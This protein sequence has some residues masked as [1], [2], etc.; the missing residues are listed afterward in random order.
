MVKDAHQA[1]RLCTR[2]SLCV[3]LFSFFINVLMLTVPLYSLQIFDRVLGGRSEETL[4][5]LTIVAVGAL[6]VHAAL[7]VV[8]S[9]I[10]VHIGNWLDRTLGPSILSQAIEGSA[11]GRGRTGIQGLRDLQSL[12]GFLTGPTIFTVFDAP[13][14]P[15]YMGVVYLVHPL[16]GMT[17]LVGAVPLF[18][19]GL[20][21][22]W[23]TRAP[24]QMAN[25]VATR[26]LQSAESGARNAEVIDAMGMLPQIV[27]RW[28]QEGEQVI[29]LQATASHRAGLIGGATKF[30]RSA[31][32]IALMAVGAWL[33]L[34][35]EV[36]PGAM[37]A[38]SII[39]GRALA[40]VEQL[41]GSWRALAGARQSYA[42]L[43]ELLRAKP[44]MRGTTRYPAPA[45]MLSVENL[46]FVPPGSSKP[47]LNGVSF[48]LLPGESLGVVGPSGAGKSVLAR[49]LTGVW[50]ATAGKV[51]LDGVDVFS[52]DRADFGRHV[53]YL[54]Q[55]VELFA[56]TIKE[57]I[58]RLDDAEDAA[59]DAD[60]IA[61]AQ[62]ANAHDLILRLP[63][64][65]D[66]DIGEAGALLSGGQRQRV[67]LARAL[68]G[69]PRFIVLDEPNSNLD[70][71]GEA[72]LTEAL[73]AAKE[74]GATI[75]VIAHRMNVLTSV[76]KIL[77]VKQ[78][79][80]ELFGPRAEVL[81]RLQPRPVPVATQMQPRL[82]AV[83]ANPTVV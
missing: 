28:R 48:R 8:R 68:Y 66:T 44:L 5:M 71:E 21:N 70:S 38:G 75:I 59:E 61:A 64:G 57:N 77:L 33:A 13:W 65:Y 17:A 76:D 22:D 46:S 58:A 36:T 20:L 83:P 47:V 40:P 74:R 80:I 29:A 37:I 4:V 25:K 30:L 54:P 14:V 27:N 19:V 2:P 73:T 26:Q 82:A 63:K 16:M 81:A 78:G 24:I 56:G 79:R 32:Q 69:N 15:V 45:G 6:A 67:A 49:L 42:Q 1:L 62:A 43:N 39:M 35:Q 51:R 12:R 11:T 7:E 41:I 18:M 53:G 34:N 60:V 3:G 55:D 72:A 10:L 31:I 50:P 23:A 52:W 9:R